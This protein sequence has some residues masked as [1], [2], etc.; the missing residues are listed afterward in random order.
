M[1]RLTRLPEAVTRLL[2]PLKAHCS[3]RHYWVFCWLLVAHLGCDEKAPLQ[4]LARSIPRHVAAGPWR[5]L[6]AAGRW[7]G[8]CVLEWRVSQTL[9]AFPPRRTESSIWWWTVR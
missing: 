7:Q 2:A 1:L 6:R 8:A 4:A 9:V 3:Y 5:R